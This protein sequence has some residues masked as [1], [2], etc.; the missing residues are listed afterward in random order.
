MTDSHKAFCW[1]S[2]TEIG[3]L[4]QAREMTSMAVTEAVLVRIDRLEPRLH[5][6]ATVTANLARTQAEQADREIAAGQIRGPLH[7]VPIALKDLCDTQGIVTS[8]GMPLNRNRIPKRDA[9]VVERLRLAGAV[10]LGKLQMTE[11]A[12]SAHHPEII[13]PVNPWGE[14]YWSGVSSSG[15]GV[16][17][18][19]G[20][21]YGSLGSDTLGSIRFPST[22]NGLTGLKPTFGRVSV[23]G[24]LPLAPS[25]DHVGPMTR[26]AADAAAM[27]M[28]IAGADPADPSAASEPV[29]DYIA[30]LNH[31]VKGLRIGID[32]DLINAY[33]ESDVAAVT[34]QAGDVL[35]DLGATLVPVSL[36]EMRGI[37]ADALNLTK[38]ELA[39]VH[40]SPF[41]QHRAQYGPVLTGLIEGGQQINAAMVAQIRE[42]REV[43]VAEVSDVFKQVDLFILPAM[44]VAAP[45]I[46]DLDKQNTDLEARLARMIFTSPINMSRHPSLTLPGG[47][48]QRGV[49]I[50]FQLIGPH[51]AEASVLMAGHAYQ[52]ATQ[53]H[54]RRPLD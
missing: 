48:T 52:Q 46:A 23:A 18:A 32:R 43:F 29:P 14:E 47:K 26:C 15:S 6:Y 7:G 28:A 37:A 5:S 45:T 49:P 33:A 42:R 44:N 19:A 41:D 24:V 22:V 53:W 2:L 36:P 11:G 27:L 40:A 50:G 31:G 51:F 21:C 9:T 12:F 1:Q 4:I 38:A 35:T 30:T 10:L 16:A 54:L 20:L 17:T 3:S 8:G 13:A 39:N 34:E 25:M